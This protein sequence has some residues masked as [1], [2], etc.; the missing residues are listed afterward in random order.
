MDLNTLTVK[1][2]SGGI[3]EK[4]FSSED[5]VSQTLSAIGKKDP[6]LHAYLEVFRDEALGE[7]SRLDSVM[8]T[9]NTLPPLWGVPIALKDN[10]LIE[11]KICSAASRILGSYRASYD[12]AVTKK[13]KKAG[14]VIIGRT[15]MDEF[16]M[17]SSTENSGYGRTKNP[18]DTSRVPGGSSGGSAVAV[19]ADMCAGALGS[20]T[21]GSI[22]QPAA[23]CGV[24]GFKPTYGAVSRSGL[25]ALAS[26]LDQIGPFAKT[27]EDAKII[28]DCL[29][30]SD[31]M[32]STTFGGLGKTGSRKAKT[33]K[34]N[35]GLPKEYFGKGLEPEVKRIVEEGIK[36][37]Q[38]QGHSFKEISLP[39]SEYALAAYYIILPAEVSANL[40]RF[41]GIRYGHHVKDA[42]KLYEVYARSRAEG[43]GPEV[44]RRVMLGTYILS[45]GYYD[46]YYLKAQKVRR[47]IK[48]D[49]EKAFM[50]V[51]II[52]GPTSPVLPFV[53][54]ERSDPLSM[55]LADIYTVAVNLAGLPG[56]SLNGGYVEQG[57]KKLPVGI[58]LI[59]PWFE[60]E[61]LFS[62]AGELEAEIKRPGSV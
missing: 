31:P 18:H 58:Q 8:G 38:A 42:S 48:E 56:I 35:I 59:S 11:G 37:L 5:V 30:G 12:S 61:K 15:N 53:S 34:M 3:R 36:K 29:R 7:A 32:D 27:V 4:K 39:M 20:D 51:D 1:G 23:F 13:L 60:E 55:Y 21:G 50:D 2:I 26:S 14:A 43:F 10:I 57:G 16:A 25:I 44:K 22:R 28:F 41:D 24:V 62:L 52:L 9:F 40:A 45:A 19:A 6:E 46:A 17:G 49:F 47:L 33:G 54:G